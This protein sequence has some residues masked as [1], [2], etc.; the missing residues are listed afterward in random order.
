MLLRE[1][2]LS[3][4]RASY[5]DLDVPARLA[6]YAG[7]WAIKEFTALIKSADEINAYKSISIN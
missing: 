1:P 5:L 2:D 4:N 7:K 3:L 6:G